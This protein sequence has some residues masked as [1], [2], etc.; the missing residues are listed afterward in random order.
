MQH[1]LSDM[2]IQAAMDQCAAE[3][4]HIPGTVQPHGC[5][6]AILPESRQVTYA[7]G[8][9]GDIIG[10]NVTDLLGQSLSGHLPRGFWHALNNALALPNASGALKTLGIFRLAGKDIDCGAF[11]SNDQVVLEFEPFIPSDL[12]GITPIR[13]LGQFL[14]DIESCQTLEAFYKSTSEFFHYLSG[15]D[16]VMIYRFDS[17]WNGNVVK[18]ERRQSMQSFEGVWFP[19]WD[20]PSQARD[21][22]TR[23]PIRV[24]SDVHQTPIPLHN[25][26]SLDAPLDISHAACR[27]VSAVHM[28]YLQNMGIAAS[29]TLSLMVDGALWGIVSFHHMT[30]RVPNAELRELLVHAGQMM[31][32]K[33]QV[34]L[35]GE[36]LMLVRKVDALKDRILR[37]LGERDAFLDFAAEILDVFDADGLVLVSESTT[38]TSGRVVEAPLLDA[39]KEHACNQD[40]V[41]TFTQLATRFHDL[42]DSCN[43]CAGALAYALDPNR[44]FFVFR[45]EK[46]RSISWAGN[47]EK[48]IENTKGRA[49]LAPRGSFTTFVES[50]RGKSKAW[51][52]QDVYFASRIW[53][54]IN[55]V[56]RRELISSLNRQQSL[57]IDELNH[58]VRNI[59]ALVRSVSEQARNT[60]DGSMDSYARSLEARIEALAASHDLTSTGLADGVPLHVLIRREFEPFTGAAQSRVQIG[61]INPVIKPKFAPIFSLVTHELVTNAVKYG[62]LSAHNGHVQI[63][64]LDVRDGVTLNW[65]E[66][67][68]PAVATPRQRGFGTSL[69]E[70]AVPYELNGTATHHFLRDGVRAEFDFPI[71]IFT[72]QML[73]ELP[74]EVTA[75]ATFDAFDVLEEALHGSTCLLVEDSFMIAKATRKIL[76]D[77]GVRHV[78]I[79]S[80]VADAL[81]VLETSPPKFAVLDIN[82]G[83]GRTSA[84]V[85][86]E[87][88]AR[89]I[90]FFCMTGYGETSDVPD[91]LRE[92]NRL[93][94]PA[95]ISDVA[96]ALGEIFLTEPAMGQEG[97]TYV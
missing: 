83:S 43:D 28:Q 32:T 2:D 95:T 24:I 63:D 45:S 54:L 44:C 66:I 52:E 59:L 29:M 61:G 58:R 15:Y 96:N 40:G 33:L 27:G 21:M 85:A 86:E 81:G 4:A 65:Q 91:A 9:T 6:I 30:P 89:A 7:S 75:P 35:Q 62:A 19:H 23:L 74:P 77:L 16:R 13:L 37:D 93:T 92:A 46:L 53:T 14:T 79:C 82:M 78:D 67:N 88:S 39:L 1:V 26:G 34:L 56:E 36:R 68:G 38:Q 97:T 47:P 60:T 22:M 12:K 84:A 17:D 18:E 94:K 71:S 31:A 48:R 80:T 10:V 11:R 57:M 50:V 72:E 41:V 25:A 20:I 5:L 49:R 51:S 42:V 55:S 70:Q 64:I 3:P 90:P 8:N 76:E 87:L 73:S 69:I